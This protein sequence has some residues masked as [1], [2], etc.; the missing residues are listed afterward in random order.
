MRMVCFAIVLVASA[1]GGYENDARTDTE[2]INS[3]IYQGIN[4]SQSELDNS[5]L[6]ALYHPRDPDFPNFWPRPCSAV[7]VK[8]TGGVST[9]VT[10]RHCLTTNNEVTGDTLIDPSRL[11][12]VRTLSPGVANPNPPAG[13]ITPFAVVEKGGLRDDIAMVLASVDWKPIADKRIGMWV[14]DPHNLVGT[15]FTAYGYGINSN[16]GSCTTNGNITTGAGVARSGSAFTVTQGQTWDGIGGDGQPHR[17]LHNA[18]STGGQAVFCGDSGG[19]D[20]GFISTTPGRTLLGVHETGAG[21]VDDV[22]STAFD[23]YLQYAVGGLYL[24][25]NSQ[26]TSDN[27]VGVN[28]NDDPRA[29]KMVARTSNDKLTVTYDVP[30]KLL[31]I[32]GGWSCF[33]A[34]TGSAALAAD[35]NY[36]DSNQVWTVHTNGQLTNG[37]GKCLTAGSS[38]LVLGPCITRDFTGHIV[39]PASTTWLFHPQP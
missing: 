9:I 11:R 16:D 8:S 34:A 35:C 21:T 38:S 13:G 4:I 33:S 37:T 6:V 30:T 18:T 27:L 3:A 1:C 17:Y 7:I 31:L 29:L 39:I 12:L 14:G 24:T 19:P 36:G 20:E 10:A 25:P 26:R 15:Q 32:E 5:G 2:T 23:L 28:V 22:E